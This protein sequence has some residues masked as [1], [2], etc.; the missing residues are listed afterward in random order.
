M[1]RQMA[2]SVCRAIYEKRGKVSQIY[3]GIWSKNLL[4]APNFAQQY[5]NHKSY[6]MF[7]GADIGG[8]HQLLEW[9]KPSHFITKFVYF[10]Q[11]HD[12][13]APDPVT[14]IRFNVTDNQTHIERALTDTFESGWMHWCNIL[15]TLHLAEELLINLLQ[16]IAEPKFRVCRDPFVPN[17]SKS[18]HAPIQDESDTKQSEDEQWMEYELIHWLALAKL[19][20]N[21]VHEKIS[22]TGR[23]KDFKY[24][25]LLQ[26]VAHHEEAQ[27]M[28]N[29]SYRLK[30]EYYTFINP[31]FAKYTIQDRQKVLDNIQLVTRRLATKQMDGNKN[32]D[33]LPC[34][35]WPTVKYSDTHRLALLGTSWMAIMWLASCIMPLSMIPQDSLPICL[36][37]VYDLSPWLLRYQYIHIYIY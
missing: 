10:H 36:L 9:I 1:D 15:H 5:D 25:L 26:R 8:M 20:F 7:R 28:N 23:T 31:Y 17:A 35:L 27:G 2:G 33:T 3:A 30:D 22:L 6:S 16:L 11:L 29:A 14:E 12:W 18:R 34:S 13:F 24:H 37:I 4:D 21:E 32:N 19:T